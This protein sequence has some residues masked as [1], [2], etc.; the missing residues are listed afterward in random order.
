[1]SKGRKAVECFNV[2]LVRPQDFIH[3]DAYAGAARQLCNGLRRLGY[4][5]RVAENEIVWDATNVLV[6]A[7]HLELELIERLPAN[8]IVYNVEMVVLGSP[9]LAVLGAFLRRFEA[10]DY[11][12]ANIAAW[13][14]AGISDRVRL[15]RPGY[16]PEDTTI[17]VTAASDIDALFY[18]GIN[19]RRDLILRDIARTGVRLH[20]AVN[21]YGA[22]RDAL[23]A[24]SKLIVNIHSRE[25]SVLEF[26]RISQALANRRL[27]V[28]EPGHA[29]DVDAQLSEAL[30]IGR[31]AELGTICRALL[32]DEPRRLALA[33]R[34]FA[35]YSQRDFTT[36]LRE[37]LARRAE[38]AIG[39]R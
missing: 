34:A 29:G 2:L 6:G 22:A 16:L 25:D 35:I 8:T 27:L 36:S 26:A 17:D 18:G 15:L 38:G 23:I 21:I 7:Q 33:E 19:W 4:P 11:S 5:A 39:P 31:A 14:T 20:V 9:F 32:D 1:V 37:L 24:R 28:T 3:H 13:R 12:A 10:W 30:V